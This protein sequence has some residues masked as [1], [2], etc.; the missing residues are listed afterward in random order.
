MTVADARLGVDFGTTTT[1]VA[2]RIGDQV[3]YPLPLGPGDEPYIPSLVVVQPGSEP[4]EQRTLVGYAAAQ[5]GQAGTPV[6]H[7]VKRCLGC[8]G[9]ERCADS[10]ANGNSW[11]AGDGK[12]HPPGTGDSIAPEELAYL[13]VRAALREAVRSANVSQKLKLGTEL[14]RRDAVNFGCGAAFTYEQRGLLVEK[15]ARKLGFKHAGWDNVIEEPIL[16]GFAFSRFSPDLHGRVLIYDFGGGSF[17]AAILDVRQE[18]GRQAITVLATAGENWLGGDDID[19]LILDDFIEAMAREQK[20]EPGIVRHR[21]GNELWLLRQRAKEWKERLSTEVEI[22][23]AV[24]TDEFDYVVLS[25]T[26]ERVEQ[27]MMASRRNGKSLIQE[28]LDTVLRAC[29]LV[30]ALDLAQESDLLAV[31]RVV[32]LTLAEA[33]YK[34][35]HVVLVGGVTKMPVVRQE[36]ERIFGDGKIVAE[37]VIAPVTAVAAGAAYPHELKHYSLAHPPYELALKIG[38]ELPHSIF[39]PYEYYDFFRLW[40]TNAK[41][42]HQSQLLDVMENA[43]E[44]ALLTRR[45]DDSQWTHLSA[46]ALSAMEPGRWRFQ[47]DLDGTVV[48]VHPDGRLQELG[49][50]PLVHPLQEEIHRQRALRQ[51]KAQQSSNDELVERMKTGYWDA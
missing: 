43:R 19:S 31:D 47:I 46:D 49:P 50:F 37:R 12:I 26:R 41:A 44:V 14:L 22:Q 40:A 7:S 45:V 1:A 39:R 10:R 48:V 51:S 16:A 17:D 29:K 3:A 24:L 5:A 35:D 27:L 38:P 11:C 36:L 4:L 21:L 30:Y 32:R 33:A 15:V 8:Q 6:I 34:L 13:I 42:T 25:L 23:D 2:L 28:S 20:L 18:A 9:G